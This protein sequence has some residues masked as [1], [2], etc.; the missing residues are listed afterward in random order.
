M[1]IRKAKRKHAF[2]KMAIQGPSGAGKTYSALLLAKGLCDNWEYITVIDTE[3][4]SSDLYAHLGDFNVLSLS[5]PYTPE[6]YIEAIK[7]CN[8]AKSKV[9]IIDSIS[10]EWMGTGGILD[11]HSLMAGNSFTNWAKLTP[12]HNAFVS[13]ILQTPAYFICTIRAK[14]DYVLVEKNNKQVPEKVGLNGI[15]RDDLSYE[16]TLVFDID[17]K[18]QVSASKDR[19]GLFANKPEFKINE[20]TGKKIMEWCQSETEDIPIE[21]KINECNSLEDLIF[22]YKSN[23]DYQVSHNPLFSKKKNELSNNLNQH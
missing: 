7:L 5:A 18:N 20:D 8:A 21:S 14:Q 11:T 10:Q 13:A 6:K 15:T 12:R 3:N 19:T 22:L 9:I 16:F 17:I 23:P 2:I 1:I 4:S